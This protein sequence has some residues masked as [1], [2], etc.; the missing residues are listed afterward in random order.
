M[1]NI[2]PNNHGYNE[3]KSIS[4]FKKKKKQ[5]KN[6]ETHKFYN[7]YN[8]YPINIIVNSYIIQISRLRYI[9]ALYFCQSANI[10]FK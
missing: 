3:S 4:R 6:P 1:Y 9:I 5:L 7:T 8:I 2:L 10:V